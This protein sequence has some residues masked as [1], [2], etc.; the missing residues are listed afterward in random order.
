MGGEIMLV[1]ARGEAKK[2]KALLNQE[3]YQAPVIHEFADY[4]ADFWVQWRGNTLELG[5]TC[6]TF[7]MSNEWAHAVANELIKK[8]NFTNARH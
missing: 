7:L 2:I 5:F 6:N 8:F 4:P 3:A 1:P